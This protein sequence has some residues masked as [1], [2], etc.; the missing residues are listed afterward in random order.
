MPA[1]NI[2]D[3]V[4]TSTPL[5]R[6]AGSVTSRG[7]EAWKTKAKMPPGFQHW[8]APPLMKPWTPN[9]VDRI[10]DLAGKTFGRFTVVGILAEKGGTNR[11]QRWVCRC[12]C[13][14][15]EARSGK[16]ISMALAGMVDTDGVGYRCWNCAQWNATQARYK[17]KG[18]R[19][20]S[21]FLN[22]KPKED[23]PEERSPEEIMASRLRELPEDVRIPVARD[24]IGHLM[25][26]GYRIVR[27]KSP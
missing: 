22:P 12:S 8:D 13:G 16:T 20:L 24:I 18:A 27:D 21:E 23:E 9:P 1:K 11:G 17:K 2:L 4:I 6:S 25:K 3:A 15:Y 5:N 10:G 19:D 14:D 7:E 26:R